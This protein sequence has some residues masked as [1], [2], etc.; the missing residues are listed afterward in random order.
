MRIIIN[1]PTYN[2]FISQN[3]SSTYKEPNATICQDQSLKLNQKN[4][5]SATLKFL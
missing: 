1:S 4:N 3:K 2:S 5:P